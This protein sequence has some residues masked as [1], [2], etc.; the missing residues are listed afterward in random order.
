[1][2]KW[3]LAES[4]LLLYTIKRV[5]KFQ[6]ET[7]INYFRNPYYLNYWFCCFF[8]IYINFTQF[9]RHIFVV[10]HHTRK[11]C[12][13]A[14]FSLTPLSCSIIGKKNICPFLNK[15]T[16]QG[17]TSAILYRLHKQIKHVKG[18]WSGLQFICHMTWACN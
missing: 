2:R 14:S 10:V 1:M 5:P 16:F 3:R 12:D 13:L 17:K 11:F 8:P 15:Q 4:Q 9:L 18:N 6:Y 7:T